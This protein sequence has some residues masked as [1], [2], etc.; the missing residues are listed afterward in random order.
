[1]VTTRKYIGII[2]D[3][4]DLMELFCEALR[5]H[6]FEPK[7]F[8]DPLEAINYL[9]THHQ[10]FLMILTDI[11]IP[12]MN[13]FQL[14][15]LMKQMDEEIKIICMSAFDIHDNDLIEIGMD[16]FLNKPIHIDRL[17]KVITDHILAKQI[18]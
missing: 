5:S 2:D 7:G 17:I 14:T 11:R 4:R 10:E 8:T 9:T 18:Q 12:E 1:M 15:K 3:E 6:S 16:E 13:G